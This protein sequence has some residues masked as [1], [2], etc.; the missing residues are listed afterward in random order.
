MVKADPRFI[1]QRSGSCHDLV[2]PSHRVRSGLERS[3]RSCALDPF[4][5]GAAVREQDLI[6]P[7]LVVVKEPIGRC[8]LG[9]AVARRWKLEGGGGSLMD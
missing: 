7:D 5:G 2:R 6:L 3:R 8:R 4:E 1:V 9:A